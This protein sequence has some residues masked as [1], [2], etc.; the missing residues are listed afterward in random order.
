MLAEDC[1]NIFVINTIDVIK[2]LTQLRFEE[3][4]AG[5]PNANVESIVS[6]LLIPIKWTYRTYYDREN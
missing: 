6:S 4:L 3:V 2:L 1:N 5:T